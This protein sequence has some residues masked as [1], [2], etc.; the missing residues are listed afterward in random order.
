MVIG[1]SEED[2][3]AT[4]FVSFVSNYSEGII[5][6]LNIN[7]FY[8]RGRAAIWASNHFLFLLF[9]SIG[10][11]ETYLAVVSALVSNE[12][13]ITKKVNGIISK[14]FKSLYSLFYC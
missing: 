13:P 6:K 2:S 9:E 3:T 11:I 4:A 1:A 14:I 5:L 7:Y 8:L 12:I 10:Y